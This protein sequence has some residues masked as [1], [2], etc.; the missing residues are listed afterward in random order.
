MSAI[1]IGITE[2]NLKKVSETLRGVLAD[3]HVLYLKKRNFHWNL[4]GPRFHSLHEFFE[5]QYT[6]LE[7]SIDEI[8][9][10]I[11]QVGDVAPGSMKEMLDSASL[12]ES[13]GEKVNGDDA[14]LFLL[15]DHTAI[16]KNLRTGIQACEEEYGDVG[17]ADFLTA[18]LQQHEEMA[19]MLRSFIEKE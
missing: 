4:V 17:T 12:K 14:I 19:W 11:R 5:E 16:I 6:A 13:P 2:D 9:E 7:K 3:A 15:A 8:A 18:L 1:E 10:R